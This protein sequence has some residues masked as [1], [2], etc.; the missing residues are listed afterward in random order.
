M[1]PRKSA[2][3]ELTKDA[4][5]DVARDLFVA[6]GYDSISMRKIAKVLQCSHG[7]IYYHFKNKAEL[8]Y[9][10]INH[11]FQ[12]LNQELED[13][14][15]EN[16]IS[17]EEKLF[18]ILYRFIKFGLT[19]Q[20]HYEVMFLIKDDEVKSYLANGPYVSYQRFAEAIAKLSPKQVHMKD[21]WSLFIGLHGF[22]THYSRT[23]T[24]FEEVED[25]VKSHCQFLLKALS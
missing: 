5:I 24:T 13:T 2:Q 14:I 7:A 15:N 17:N 21:I 22:V 1:T 11:D 25:L 16:Q 12:Q 8:F 9:E 23:E 6:E 20:N 3:D 4:I 19:H 18:L 10:I